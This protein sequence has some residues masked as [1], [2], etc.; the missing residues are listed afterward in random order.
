[1][2]GRRRKLELGV[3]SCDGYEGQLYC[4]CLKRKQQNCLHC[5]VYCKIQVGEC[6]QGKG[7][8]CL[9]GILLLLLSLVIIL[10]MYG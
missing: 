10:Y 7:R 4:N 2:Q 5:L 1:M 9:D 3:E 6:G 8:L